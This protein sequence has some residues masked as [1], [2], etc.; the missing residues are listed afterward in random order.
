[1]SKT[2]KN[3]TVIHTERKESEISSERQSNNQTIKQKESIKPKKFSLKL[4]HKVL[5]IILSIAVVAAIAVAIFVSMKNRSKNEGNLGNS[6]NEKN[7]NEIERDKGKNNE[8]ENNSNENNSK[9]NIGNEENDENSGKKDNPN[10]GNNIGSKINDDKEQYTLEEI[11]EVFEPSFKINSNVDSLSQIVMKSKQ[12]FITKNNNLLDYNFIKA[13]YDIYTLSESSPTEEES[14]FYTKKYTTSLVI[15]SFCAITE[16][17]DCEYIPY[18]DLTYKNENHNLRSIEEDNVEEANLEDVIL[19]ICLIEHT[20]TNI[21]ISVSCPNILEENLKSIIINAFHNIKPETIKGFYIDEN[22]ESTT[23]EKKDNKIYINSFSKLCEDNSENNDEICE[24]NLNIITT[25]NENLISI[26]KKIKIETTSYS[27]ESDY[28]FENITSENS[29]ILD[30]A[31]YK[32]NLNKLLDLLKNY[33]VKE[34]YVTGNSFKQ[35][36]EPEENENKNNIRNLKEEIPENLGSFETNVFE[37]EYN[38]FKISLNL[39]DN[40]ISGDQS[41]TTTKI[42]SISS[43]HDNLTELSNYEVNSNITSIINEF[44]IIS[45]AAN[46][47]GT[48]L[49]NQIN[50]PLLEIRDKINSEFTNLNNILPF[51]H[52]S[53]IYDSTLSISGLNEFPFDIVPASQN[54]YNKIKSVED[55]LLYIIDDYKQILNG[56]ISSFLSNTHN[57]ISQ[58]FNNLREYNTAVS[59][60]KSKIA[61]IAVFYGLN[62]TN[63]SFVKTIENA[64]YIL[65]NYYINETDLIERLLNEIYSN[66]TEKS[67]KLVKNSHYYLDNITNRLEDESVTIKKGDIE[68][69]RTV[70]SNLYNTKVLE[71]RIIPKII[72]A[73]NLDI[74]QSNGYL[75]SQKV[76]NDNKNSYSSIGENALNT[77]K[78]LANNEYIDEDFDDIMKYFKEQYIVIINNIKKSK[79]ENFPLKTNILNSSIS[80]DELDDVFFNNKLSIK[81]WL[82]NNNKNFTNLTKVKINLFKEK[83]ESKLQNI[84]H[85]IYNN[86]LTKDKLTDLDKKYREMLNCTKENII[87][88]INYDDSLFKAYL[89]D[90]KSST[91]LTKTIINKRKIYLNNINEIKSYIQ[92]NLKNDLV[93]KYKNIINEIRKNLQSIKSNSIIKEYSEINNLS[94]FKSHIEIYINPLFLRLNDYI[95]DDNF[96]KIYLKEINEFINQCINM[97]NNLIEYYNNLYKPISQFTYTGDSSNDIYYRYDYRCCSRTWYGKKKCRTCTDYNPQKVGSTNYH[98]LLKKVN[99]E[100][101]S[102]DFDSKYKEIMNIFST[103]IDLYNDMVKDLGNELQIIINN[104]ANNNVPFLNNILEKAKSFLSNK[105]DL[106]LVQISYDYYKE[107]LEEKLPIELNLLLEQWKSLF[108]K[109][110]EDI[111]TNI[112]KFKYPIEQI[113]D[114][115]SFYYGFYYNNISYGYLDSVV[116]QRKTDFNYTIKYY[117][118]LFMSKINKTYTYILN[119][120]PINEKPFNDVFNYQISQIQNSKNEITNLFLLSENKVLN[121]KNVLNTLKV[122]ETN[123]FQVNKY[124]VDIAYK[125]EDELLPL[126]EKLDEIVEKVNNNYDTE[127]SLASRFYLENLE[128]AKQINEIYDTI[129]KGTFIDFQ[130]NDYQDLFESILEIDETDLKNKILDFLSKSNEELNEIFKN[131]KENYKKSIENFIFN[132]LYNKSAL[133]E[134]INLI[135]SK[136]LKDL[137]LVSKNKILS[138]IDDVINKIEEIIKSEKSRLLDELLSLSNDF[139]LI[140]N[141]LNELKKKIYNGFYTAIYSVTNDFYSQITQKFYTNYIEKY[142]NELY[143]NHTKKENFTQC[144]FL[145]TSFNLKEVM[146]EDIELFINEYKN[147]TLDHMIFLNCEKTKYLDELFKIKDIEQKINNKIDYFYEEILFPALNKTGIYNSGDEGISDYDFSERIT[148]DINSIINEKINNTKIIII[149]KM[150]GEKYNIDE[151]L[152]I[153]DM[154]YVKKDLFDL[155]INDDFKNAFC[156]IYIPKENSTFFTEVSKIII[157]NYKDI[158]ENFVSSFGKDYFERNLKYNEIQKIKSLYSNLKYSV[159]I[160]LLYYIFLTESNSMT[161]MPDDL[162]VKIL[163]LNNIDSIVN[164]KNNLVL[165]NLN[166]KFDEFLKLT[167]NKLIEKYIDYIAK[168]L[169]LKQSFDEKIWNLTKQVLGEQRNE[170]GNEY[171]NMMNIYIRKPFIEQ[172]TKTIEQETNE[173]LHYIEVNKEPLILVLNDLEIINKDDTLNNIEIKLNNTLK[174]IEDYNSYLKNFRLTKGVK[175]FLDNFVENYLISEHKDIKKIVDGETIN[176][177][178]DN[179]NI[180]S[181]NFNNSYKYENIEAKLNN[182]YDLFNNLFNDSIINYLKKYGYIDKKYSENLEKEKIKN[183]QNETIRRLEENGNYLDLKLDKT[184]KSLIESSKAIKQYIQSADIF[185]NFND[186][187]NNYIIAI[188]DEYECSKKFIIDR[189][190]TED[191]N[192]K[193]IDNLEDLKEL[194]ISYYNQVKERFVEIKEFIENSIIKIDDLISRS[195]KT[196]YEVIKDKYKNIADNFNSLND[197]DNN[198]T[199]NLTNIDYQSHL[200]EKNYKIAIK[201]N[202]FIYNNEFN[203][204]FLNEDGMPK[205][206]GKSINKNRPMSFTVDFSY[207]LGKCI[208]KGKEM[209]INL[210]N[211]SSNIDIDFDS[212]SIQTKIIKN[213]NIDE[214]IIDNKYYNQ[215]EKPKNESNG[216]LTFIRIKCHTQ[217]LNIPSNEKPSYT[218]E[219]KTN[220]T[221]E[222]Y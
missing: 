150:E 138:Y 19:P 157:K 195:N 43:V 61:N 202:G 35:L 93:N 112:N 34:I 66:F 171:I 110:Y 186:T 182:T 33:M 172:Y 107:Q 58:I 183:F 212:S 4:W 205:L 156:K 60:K 28:N 184:F 109:V 41:R 167:Q 65:E 125:I 200:G 102:K 132:K 54:I 47:L 187:I 178:V 14:N 53:E 99:F 145:N 96:N 50:N 129:D 131:K 214:Y 106:N 194:S 193:L 113:S 127:E 146:Y 68:H 126:S 199:N 98:T 185:S 59:S 209:I 149:E 137:D 12:N 86:Y 147:W 9:G 158:I 118:N 134:K 103:N 24:T 159:S 37:T 181:Q 20:D 120:V 169:I 144:S 190:Y 57:L 123:F 21:V 177:I 136:G 174:A 116:D 63:D 179:L 163:T 67:E 140:K 175:D 204:Y 130:N 49:Y 78:Q 40:I 64:K 114:L 141:R 89:N 76:I 196:T 128:N 188:K 81:E 91:H 97:I 162:G 100:D 173:M 122:A 154:S 55:D 42:N 17:T 48:D 217:N 13:K 208:N 101:Y 221:I 207:K 8:K 36:M 168:N 45:K 135:Y 206:K 26:N 189:K 108:N 201:I 148:T 29:E 77:A 85:N 115:A 94:F 88:I 69:I 104:F 124:G 139:S 72:E 27:N 6:N 215:T 220:T 74:K 10:G 1:M 164:S 160:T 51:K 203:F 22:L 3:T 56:D 161:L 18:L 192:K 165:S 219:A 80:F 46:S 210:N 155:L 119:N 218:V 222:I 44:K 32:S 213:Y 90:V 71:N 170:L 166:S 133:E 7:D 11:K 5:I 143:Y 15:N 79:S 142:L 73:M 70:I 153:P 39:S 62:N 111:N 30:H 152:A 151:N 87:N 211:I 25:K 121:L 52:L 198:K 197:K 84:M 105:L 83:N 38:S 2:E 180:N 216:G 95:S 92:L 117:Y 191:I 75:I 16:G 82:D 31:N 23:I 176:I